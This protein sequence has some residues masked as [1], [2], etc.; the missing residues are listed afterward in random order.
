MSIAIIN[1]TEHTPI[2]YALGKLMSVDVE[3][4]PEGAARLNSIEL[5]SYRGTQISA[6]DSSEWYCK[7]HTTIKKGFIIKNVFSAYSNFFYLLPEGLWGDMGGRMWIRENTFEIER[8]VP[9]AGY[10]TRQVDGPS[11]LLGEKISDGVVYPEN[12][13][14]ANS[15]RS[16]YS[17]AFSILHLYQTEYHSS[18]FQIPNYIRDPSYSPRPSTIEEEYQLEV[19]SKIKLTFGHVSKGPIL[20]DG[21]F[22]AEKLIV[23]GPGGARVRQG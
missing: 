6:S 2:G 4:V 9:T 5:F 3:V 14:Q 21:F 13:I 22:S 18:Y 8:D 23:A 17:V 1:S 7:L 20:R 10:I 16:F 19:P 15:G 12:H 11:Y